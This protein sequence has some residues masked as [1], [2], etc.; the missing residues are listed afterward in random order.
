MSQ[1][2]SVALIVLHVLKS[3][4]LHGLLQQQI[5]SLVFVE[6]VSISGEL[7]FFAKTFVLKLLSVFF[8]LHPCFNVQNICCQ[9]QDGVEVHNY[10]AVLF[11]L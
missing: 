3:F 5:L 2:D 9:I 10:F 8:L 4:N 6:T 1:E 11:T 7:L